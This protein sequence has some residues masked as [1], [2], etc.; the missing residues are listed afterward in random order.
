MGKPEN[1]PIT[2]VAILS[3][4]GE[5]RRTTHDVYFFLV[6]NGELE[7]CVDG[8]VISAAEQ[9][10][11]MVGEKEDF[12][13]C[14]SGNNLVLM[15]TLSGSFFA[16]GRS[17]VLGTFVCNSVTDHERDYSALRRLLAQIALTNF[18]QTDINAIHQTG[19]AHELLYFLNRYHYVAHTHIPEQFAKRKYAERYARIVSYVERNYA[20]PITLDELA[21]EVYLT[22]TYLSR[23]FPRY[24]NETF[25]SYI[26]K[27]RV[28]HARFDLLH[29]DATLTAV[30]YNN[31]FANLSAFNRSFQENYGISPAKFRQKNKEKIVTTD[32]NTSPAE[33]VDFSVTKPLLNSLAETGGNGEL[34]IQF[35]RQV[36][37]QVPAVHTCKVE[38]PIWNTMINLGDSSFLNDYT[39]QSHI[40]LAQDEIGFRYGRLQGVLKEDFL[41]TRPGKGGYNFSSFDRAISMLHSRGLTPF[42]DLTYRVNYL[43]MGK[44]VPVYP[45][46]E[47]AAEV[48][49]AQFLEKI[50]ALIQHCINT[51][52]ILE[53][54]RWCFEIGYNHDEYLNLS[55]T[56]AA[57]ARRFAK[58]YRIIKELLPNAMV[59]G[60]SHNAS[61]PASVFDQIL[62]EMEHQQFSPDFISLCCFPYEHAPN[63]TEASFCGYSSDKDFI[64]NRVTALKQ[65]LADHPAMRQTLYLT[66]LG[67]DVKVRN[68]LHDS[69]FQSAFLV[70]N[71]IDLLGLVDLVGYWQLSDV[72]AEYVDSNSILFGGSGIINKDGLKKPGFTALKRMN[73]LSSTIIQKGEEY[74]ISTN[75]RGSYYILLS[76]YIHPSEEFCIRDAASVALTEIYTAFNSPC[77]KDV[78]IQLNKL[79]SG[80][81]K[82]ATTSLNRERGSLLDEWMR[83]GILENLQPRDIHYF[84]DIVHPHRMVRY[85]DCI[86]EPLE[87][88][89]QLLP[90]E[91]KFIEIFQEV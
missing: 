85:V 83:Y 28:E 60:V 71:T 32:S 61:L 78:V 44:W 65:M 69:C 67:L 59:G 52:G 33:T 38:Q 87:L 15:I 89:I 84:R 18:E 13:I 2:N 35:P 82:V 43:L 57:F 77:T 62:V 11:I 46:H 9:A 90:H 39:L 68:P 64:K 58:C 54:E 49:Q 56:P 47:V 3:I 1:H 40:A 88:H 45:S 29:T 36:F 21:G 25:S 26:N 14:A 8:S 70:K 73:Y 75:G 27:V 6:I 86:N 55:E 81:Y 10:V 24:M 50:S 72:A 91:I 79:P 51:F 34:S 4:Q 63:Q 80:Q 20:S 66:V 41:P 22:S 16:K 7:F 5:L 74:L 31:G 42:L 23:F 48:T 30:A 12:S 37:Y 19:M 17:S 53:V 76:N